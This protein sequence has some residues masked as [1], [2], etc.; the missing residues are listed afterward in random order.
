[1]RSLGSLVSPGQE[2]WAG[3][4]AK[5]VLNERRCLRFSKKLLGTLS[6]WVDFTGWLERLPTLH[7]SW[8]S[9][10]RRA[11]T[12]ALAALQGERTARSVGRLVSQTSRSAG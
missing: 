9:S 4:Q 2:L 12:I 5:A 3:R 10:I 6:K 1:M 8:S 7:R 11:A